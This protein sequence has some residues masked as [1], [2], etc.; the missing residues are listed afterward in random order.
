VK[1]RAKVSEKILGYAIYR[2]VVGIQI[3]AAPCA[4]QNKTVQDSALGTPSPSHVCELLPVGRKS[5]EAQV[6]PPGRLMCRRLALCPDFTRNQTVTSCNL[7]SSTSKL[8]ET[9]SETS[10]SLRPLSR[11]QK[12]STLLSSPLALSPPA[13]RTWPLWSRVAVWS[14]REFCIL[15]AVVQVR[16]VGL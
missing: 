11:H 16:V 8:R 6:R 3:V 1:Q 5:R 10:V 4:R 2:R 15:L 7:I 12:S 9:T 14:T 13:A